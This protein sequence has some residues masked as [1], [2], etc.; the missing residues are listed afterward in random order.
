MSVVDITLLQ[1]LE[2]VASL[3]PEQL[4]YILMYSKIERYAPGTC[5]FRQG[6][7][8]F[9]MLYLLRGDIGL[10]S[11]NG[12]GNQMISA[13]YQ[14]NSANFHPITTDQPRRMTATTL[15]EAEVVRLDSDLVETMM[16]WNQFMRREPE[17]IMSGEGVMNVDKSQWVQ[18]M[19]RSPTFRHLPAA[20]IEQLLDSLE[21]I[22]VNAGD[23][24]IRQGDAGDYFYML[25][26]GTALVT[27]VVTGGD[28]S[29]IGVPGSVKG[30][31]GVSKSEDESIELAELSAGSSFGEAALLSDKPRN[32]SV[33][34]VT[35]GV[36]LRLAKADFV[37]LLNE[38]T[39]HWVKQGELQAKLNAG[40]RGLDVRTPSEFAHGHLQKSI[41]IPIQELHQRI[42]DLDK[43]QYY[44]CCCEAGRRSAAAAFILGQY[45]IKASVLKAGLDSLPDK[46]LMV[47]S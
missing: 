23:V 26:E 21:P 22:R 9:T 31:A 43:A 39:L 42:K 8:D 30:V 44:I 13:N 34:M 25:N 6:D 35:D 41:N 36:L 14:E 15:T 1:R 32:A 12:A 3:A 19:Y 37:R 24:I 4:E 7:E 45:G 40:A 2:P 11:E 16:V 5:L 46:S 47:K 33:S 38:P 10:S 27:R 17:V 29:A 20:N 28:G 18:K